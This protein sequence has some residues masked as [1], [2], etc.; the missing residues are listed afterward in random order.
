MFDQVNAATRRIELITEEVVRRASRQ[1][2]SAMDT[3]AQNAFGFLAGGGTL[4]F[5][6]ENCLHELIEKR[7][8]NDRD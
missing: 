3:L 7:C 2:E 5:F 6:S 4:K 1:T 8:P